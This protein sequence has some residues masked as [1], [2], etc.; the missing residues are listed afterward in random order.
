MKLLARLAEIDPGG[1]LSNRPLGSLVDIFRAWVPQT[2]LTLDRRIAVLDTLRRDHPEIAW[3]LMLA[4]LPEH[5]GAGNYTHSPRFRAW[6]P[7][8]DGVT[9]GERW[10]FESA[11]AERLI[12]D[13]AVES[14]RWLDVVEHLDRFP[15]RERASAV[16]RLRDLAKSAE[17][18]PEDRESI[19][20]ALDKIVRRHRSFPEAEWSLPDEELGDIAS[21]AETFTPSD[22]IRAH[23]WLFNDH[24]P[25]IGDARAEYHEQEA[26]VQERRTAAVADVVAA[27][28]MEGLVQLAAEVEFP[29]AVGATAAREPSDELDEQALSLLDDEDPKRASFAGGYVFERTKGAG[30][31]W[32]DEA[33]AKVIG[34]P[35]A[36]ARLLQQVDHDLPAVWHRAADLGREVEQAYWTE[37]ATW[38]RGDFQFVDEAVTNLMK[39]NRPLAALDLMALYVNKED[40]RVSPDL[41]VQGLEQL[42]RLPD[43]HHELQRVSNYELEALLDYLR[44]SDAD[45]EQLGILEWQLLPALGFDA[46]SPVLERRLA[47]DP[48][49]FVEIL[50]LVYRPRGDESE[51]MDVPEHVAT[52]AYRLLDEWKIVP[53]STDRMGAVDSEGLAAWVEVARNLA[54]DAGRGEIADIQIGKVLAH[55]RGDDDETWPTRPVRDLIER[56]ASPELEDG[57]GIEIY[58]SRGPTSRAPLAGGEQERT[59]VKRYDDLS[60][61]VRDGWPRTAA[62]LSSIARGYEREARRHDEEAER[63]RQGMER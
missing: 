30:M 46:R 51:A 8:T 13:T 7:E 19:W 54:R 33:I 20:N 35:L 18:S 39:F 12:E 60:A 53:G 28:G 44:N 47:R 5:Y 32:V 37:F 4:L 2:S 61:R 56:L 1:R 21:V 41:I 50:S 15:P 34:R 63:I 14:Q 57:F 11:V 62:V 36:Q 9:S 59:L 25:D 3:K 17:L 52:N 26:G 38:G 27:H 49:F 45:E 31:P 40:R 22:P 10:E 58:N 6:K 43:D 48:A 55:A 29:G 42:V 23:A 16:G 24:L